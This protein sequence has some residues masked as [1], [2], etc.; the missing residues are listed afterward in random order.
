M[1]R[2]TLTPDRLAL[3]N[4]EPAGIEAARRFLERPLRHYIGGELTESADG[5]TFEVISPATGESI[6]AACAAG[7]PEVEAA[8]SAA[9]EAFD[10]GRWRRLTLLEREMIMLRLADLVEA[11]ADELSV[12]EVLDNGM[13]QAFARGT[14]IRAATIIRYY[15][16]YLTKIEGTLNPVDPGF[17]SYSRREPVGVCVGITPWNGPLYVA[18]SK[19]APAIGC[20]NVMVL[21]PAE[22]T[23]VTATRLG[24]LCVEAGVPA[25]VVNIV[26]GDGGV[27]AALVA[28]PEV[29]KISFT[30]STEVGKSIQKV[31]SER[32]KRVTLELGGKS[33]DIVF[34]DADLE[35][36]VP[37][38]VNA[39]YSNTGQRCIAGSRLLVAR[40]L[41]DELAERFAKAA[42]ELVVGDG[43]DERTQLGPLISATQFDRVSGYVD[44]G[45]EEG[46][47]LVQGGSRWE[48]EGFFAEP[49]IFANVT[50]DMRIA[51]EEVFGPVVTL[52]PFDS[53]EEAIAIGN[54]T[55]YGL[56][57]GIWSSDAGRIHRV[58]ERL[59]AGMVWANCYGLYPMGVGFGGFKESGYG[60]ELGSPSIDVY[61]Q[62]KSLI[63]RIDV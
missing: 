4:G 43:F 27:G 18:V 22:D 11:A 39:V 41:H 36:T 19:I 37:G 13:P 49:T 24:E 35:I 50:N 38:T 54:D 51:R 10:D 60:R 33:P 32:L 21:K 25:G 45:V 31:A 55:R 53:E 2:G 52:L 58:A 61:T 56:A 15:A 12:L 34:A 17:L 1:S 30:G 16:G 48:G 28:H 46:A 47:D 63:Q 14:A 9:R 29:D 59:Q 6:G 57:A 7:A 62:V 26:H 44:L 5:A 8:V 20:G 42:G 3:S 23:P 40:S